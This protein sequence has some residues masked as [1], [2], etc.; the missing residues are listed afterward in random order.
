MASKVKHNHVKS[1]KRVLS[2]QYEHNKDGKQNKSEFLEGACYISV[3][4]S[5]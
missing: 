2:A 3:D 5:Y 1:H 4:I